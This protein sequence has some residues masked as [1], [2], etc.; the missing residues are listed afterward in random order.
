LIAVAPHVFA[1]GGHVPWFS[2]AVTLGVVFLVGTIA[3]VVAVFFVLRAPLLPA[4]KTD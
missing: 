2:L 4:L 3:S 1:P